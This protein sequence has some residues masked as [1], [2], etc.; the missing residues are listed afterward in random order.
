M[1]EGNNADVWVALDT[2]GGSKALGQIRREGLFQSLSTRISIARGGC[3]LQIPD[4]DTYLTN[5][6]EEDVMF[7]DF[8]DYCYTEIDSLDSEGMSVSMEWIHCSLKPF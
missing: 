8:I 7:T 6:N 2:S 1:A 3:P 5:F 4:I